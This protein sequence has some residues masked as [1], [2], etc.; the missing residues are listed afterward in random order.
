MRPDSE[1]LIR[2]LPCWRGAIAIEPLPGG[3]SNSNF[4]VADGSGTYV[5][6]LGVDFPFH[7]VS[8]R[9]E[10]TA[11]GWAHAAGL[12]PEVIYADNRAL[13]CRFVE[14]RTYSADDVRADLARVV[15]LIKTCHR[16]MPDHVRGE[17]CLF[18]VFHVLRDYAY[19]LREAGDPIVG[20]LPRLG[21]I[22]RELE[23]AQIPLPI[24]FGHNDLLPANFIADTS[25][26]WLID[27]EYA[28]FGTAL[29][30]LANVAQN[31]L[32][33]DSEETRLLELYFER[34]PQADLL[35]SFAA[36]KTASALR[37]ALW[38]CVSRVFLDAPGADYGAY[39]DSCMKRFE[40]AHR[41]YSRK[42][43]QP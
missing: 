22:A 36:M 1:A 11:A 26:L 6:R 8:R 4:K 18:W 37:E 15:A 2:A 25:R 38:A 10:A 35:R 34:T 23:M 9:R 32:F 29:F 30:D 21:S 24:V 17:A 43:P 41:D 14:G 12:S 31:A 13:V 42:Y 19:T 28:G 3:L 16:G 40:S 20:D 5:A 39:A 7:H 33:G 27:W